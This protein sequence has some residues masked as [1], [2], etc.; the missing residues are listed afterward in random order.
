MMTP[1]GLD[2]SLLE[3]HGIPDVYARDDIQYGGTH[4]AL[5]EVQR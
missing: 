4:D 2:M 3:A 5:W 1:L